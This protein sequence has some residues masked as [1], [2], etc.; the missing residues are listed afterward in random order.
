ARCF[1]S[2]GPSIFSPFLRWKTEFKPPQSNIEPSSV[3]AIACISSVK[4]Y[5]AALNRVYVGDAKRIKNRLDNPR[6]V[7][8]ESVVNLARDKRLHLD[9][10]QGARCVCS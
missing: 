8:V 10:V 9:N 4:S 7:F 1:S 6:L 3:T 5:P 2:N